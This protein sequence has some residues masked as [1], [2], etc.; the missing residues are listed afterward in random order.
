MELSEVWL[1]S[2]SPR[3][4]HTLAGKEKSFF[5]KFLACNRPAFHFAGKHVVD[6]NQTMLLVQS[7]L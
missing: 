5:C 4:T 3:K 7:D 6:Y 1:K 2:N